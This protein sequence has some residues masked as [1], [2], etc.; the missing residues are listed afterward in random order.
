CEKS[1]SQSSNLIY[2]QRVHTGEKSY[3]CGECGKGF[4]KSY[5]LICHQRMHTGQKPY[6]CG[7]CGKGFTVRSCL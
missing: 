6:E 7:K 3:E 1:F 4:H 2:H 5:G